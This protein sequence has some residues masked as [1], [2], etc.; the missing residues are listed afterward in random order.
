MNSKVFFVRTEYKIETFFQSERNTCCQLFLPV[1]LSSV[2]LRIGFI[3]RRKFSSL[4]DDHLNI[5]IQ[6]YRKVLKFWDPR[7]LC[8][9]LPKIQTKKPNLRG[10]LSKW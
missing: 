8:C 5:S 9:N 1:G 3:D 10:I 4:S 2:C 7:K 6:N